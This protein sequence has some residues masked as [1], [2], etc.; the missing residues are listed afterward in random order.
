VLSQEIV[1]YDREF[2]DLLKADVDK[3]G[4]IDDQWI[5]VF[6]Q[7]GMDRI[8][9][10]LSL[11]RLSGL[12]EF[13]QL[14]ERDWTKRRYFWSGSHVSN[15]FTMEVF[16]L[17]NEKFLGLDLGESFWTYAGG[18]D[19]YSEPHTPITYIDVMG[20]GLTWPQQ[21]VNLEL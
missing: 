20:Y 17:L 13:G 12:P 16:R 21:P 15:V 18:H 2:H 11:C 3:V 5:G 4:R 19:L 6:R 7:K 14:F 10:F 1:N 9:K 8:E